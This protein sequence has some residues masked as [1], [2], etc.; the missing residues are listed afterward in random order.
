MRQS[1][2][3]PWGFGSGPHTLDVYFWLFWFWLID[4][5]RRHGVVCFSHNGFK[6]NR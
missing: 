4:L 2:G 5:V 1:L 3:A 6:F